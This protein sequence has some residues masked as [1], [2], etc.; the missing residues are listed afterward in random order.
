MRGSGAGQRLELEP[1]KTYVRSIRKNNEMVNLIV[2][3]IGVCIFY[4]LYFYFFLNN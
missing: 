3:P 2:A 4:F 1:D